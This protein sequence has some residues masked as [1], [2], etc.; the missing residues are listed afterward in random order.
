MVIRTGR[1]G[2]FLSCTGYPQCN[3][4]KPVPL[5]VPCP[6]CGGDLIEVRSK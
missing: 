1:Y 3:N 2:E 6:K 5:G 4:A